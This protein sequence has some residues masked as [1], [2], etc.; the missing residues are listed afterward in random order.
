MGISQRISWTIRM[1]R[2]FLLCLVVA[3]AYA[4]PEAEA[5]A[6]ADPYFYY[7][8][9][10]AGYPYTYGYAPLAVKPAEVAEVKAADEKTPVVTYA[11]HPYAYAGYAGLHGLGYGYGYGLGYPY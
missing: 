4:E 11:H 8:R 10:Y 2:A 6:E 3:F 1:L 5:E 9:G 7:N